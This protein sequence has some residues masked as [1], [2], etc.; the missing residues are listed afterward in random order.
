MKKLYAAL[1][2][3]ATL[4]TLSFGQSDNKY[5][6]WSLG[7]YTT[8]D[9]TYTPENLPWEAFT[10]IAYFQVWPNSDGTL[11]LPNEATAKRVISEGH[12]RGKKVIFCVG[13]AGVKD[14]FKGACS[15]AN[16]G[17]FISNIL[18]YLKKLGYDGFDTDWEEN[19]DDALFQ[20][21]HK[22]L[23]DSIN[24]LSPVP[25]MT[26]AAEDWFPITAKVHQYVD[27]VNNMRYTG[28]SAAN[29]PKT[30]NVF[31]NAGAAKSKVGAG[32][33]ISMGMSV[34]QVTDMANMVLKEGYGGLIQWDVTKNGGAPAN[35]AAL[36]KFVNP[37]VGI[38]TS[39]GTKYREQVTLAIENGLSPRIRYSVPAA[40]A[41][42]NIDLGLYD[43]NG[44]LVK[45]LVHGRAQGGA[46]SLPLN[47]AG[48]AGTYIVRLS[49]DG[50]SKAATAFIPR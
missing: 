17:K 18:A 2:L 27:Q 11:K 10:H 9:N 45:T 12:K 42:A 31:T 44:S 41:G 40:S 16:R 19:F 5:I 22:E 33:G 30:L 1:L 34:Q 8:W 25:L 29:Y 36:A 43:M 13:G 23:R 26:I 35:M 32:L 46:Y 20:A 38:F 7:Y 50:A 28:T 21:W 15:A 24:R 37:T 49:A 39:G 14:A 47:Q 4:T 48:A 3:A 6:G